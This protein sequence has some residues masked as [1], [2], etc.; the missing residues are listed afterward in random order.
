M[1]P[2]REL[3]Q[4]NLCQL[5]SPVSWLGHDR[6]YSLQLAIKKLTHAMPGRTFKL[7]L[8]A[9]KS[10]W[11][12]RFMLSKFMKIYFRICWNFFCNWNKSFGDKVWKWSWRILNN[13]NVNT[14][15]IK[16]QFVKDDKYIFSK[17][18]TE[19]PYSEKKITFR[20]KKYFNTQYFYNKKILCEKY[21]DKF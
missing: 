19:F 2:L 20:R 18:F 11:N 6:Y 12:T 10:A 1:G 9:K 3:G 16:V 14:D 7:R 13:L 21:R 5:Y 8:K 4:G 17:L 15:I